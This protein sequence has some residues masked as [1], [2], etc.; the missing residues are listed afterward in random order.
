MDY[1]YQEPVNVVFWCGVKSFIY[2][3]TSQGYFID[4]IMNIHLFRQGLL[5]LRSRKHDIRAR[6]HLEWNFG[7]S[8]SCILIKCPWIYNRRSKIDKAELFH[9]D[10]L[11]IVQSN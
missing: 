11:N 7:K 4:S 2:S 6:R 3:Q 5:G 1:S 10:V 9:D 8:S